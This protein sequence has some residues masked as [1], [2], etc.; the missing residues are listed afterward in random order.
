M[1]SGRFLI[2]LHDVSIAQRDACERMLQ[3]VPRHLLG[4]AAVLVVPAWYGHVGHARDAARWL[5]R[6]PATRVLHGLRHTRGPSLVN[7][8]WYGTEDESECA[9]Y[10]PQDAALHLERACTAFSDIFGTPPHWYCAPRWQSSAPLRRALRYRGLAALERD[11]VTLSTGRILRAPTIWF[12]DGRRSLPS[13]VGKLQRRLRTHDV[14]AES[15]IMRVA[16]HPR[17]AV[18]PSRARDVRSLLSRLEASDWTP[19]SLSQLESAA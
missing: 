1:T 15:G 19:I 11:T 8:L 7:A 10:D 6:W 17:D 3:L 18:D 16:L 4:D 13:L 9:D 12:D 2:E 14:Y 5:A